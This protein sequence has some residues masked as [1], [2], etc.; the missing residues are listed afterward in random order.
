MQV[1]GAILP[2]AAAVSR[3]LPT[4]VADTGAEAGLSTDA[5]HRLRVI[6][7][8]E[9][10]GRNASLTC[11]HFSHSRSTFH[12]WRQ[13][14]RR[15]GPK[16][17]EDRSRRPHRVREPT[18]S[19]E[20]AQAV[21]HFRQEY[22]WGKDKLVVLARREGWEVSTS[23][24]GR[25]L[26]N[27]K[28]RG[29]LWEP[30]LRDPCM[31]RRPHKRPYATR[32]PRDYVAKAPGDLVEVDTADIRLLPG[33]VYKH[34][35]AR[36]VVGRWDVLDVHHRATGQAAAS[37][38][39]VILERMPFP[40]RAIQ[41]DGGSEFKAEF[42]EDCRRRGILLFELPPR[43]PKLNGHVERAHR[44]HREEFYQMLDPPDSLDELRDRLR[45]QET[46]YNTIR[47]HQAL[48]QRTPLEFY[49]EW[50][51][52]RTTERG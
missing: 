7:W 2:G 30:D 26:H 48:G 5:R 38:L 25:I 36:D 37:F 22:H 39:D 40:V 13:R 44:T 21:L 52:T 4:T 35:G 10:H 20:L 3:L 19:Q 14:Y 41:V 46:V 11:R 16:G 17:L 23:M 42:E 31:V 33:E 9:E 34:F 12:T 15:Q 50:L 51:A 1:Y 8:Y 32:K 49:Q 28:E 6:R 43:S 47:P 18:W 29:L 24:V 45:A 27:L